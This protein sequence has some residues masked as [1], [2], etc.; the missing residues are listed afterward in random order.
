[1]S[2]RNIIVDDED[3][4][5]LDTSESTVNSIIA[6]RFGMEED[7]ATIQEQQFDSELTD[8][9]VKDELERIFKFNTIPRFR[10]DY[11]IDLYINNVVY[12]AQTILQHYVYYRPLLVKLC[13][14][15]ITY[16]S[17]VRL[18]DYGPGLFVE[19]VVENDPLVEKD[20]DPLSGKHLWLLVEQVTNL[21][22]NRIGR[23]VYTW[24]LINIV[25]HSII[26][27]EERE[28]F[29]EL[30]KTIILDNGLYT[31]DLDAVIKELLSD[32]KWMVVFIASTY[33]KK[34]IDIYRKLIII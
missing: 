5:Q 3:D 25:P 30:V 6:R 26:Y 28:A 7:S 14:F 9:D 4:I 12:K 10:R 8:V 16:K 15:K 23:I 17:T 1:M 31:N 13:D 21:Y 11:N 19:K 20:D 32:I 34:Y 22:L 29:F 27:R 33:N 2:Q 24:L 18:T